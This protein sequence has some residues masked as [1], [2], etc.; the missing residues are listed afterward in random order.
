VFVRW[1]LRR[2]TDVHK[3]VGAVDNTG[4]RFEERAHYS[5]VGSTPYEVQV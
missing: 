2:I 3:I 4:W 1:Q 5:L